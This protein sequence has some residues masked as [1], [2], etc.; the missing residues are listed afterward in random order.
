LSVA[1]AIPIEVLWCLTLTGSFFVNLS[2]HAMA[3]LPT[4][5]LVA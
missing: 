1:V 3:S 5:H 2:C 4:R